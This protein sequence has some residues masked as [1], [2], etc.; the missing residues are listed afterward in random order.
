LTHAVCVL[1]RVVLVCSSV[2]VGSDNSN[3]YSL[4]HTHETIHND[5]P[6]RR[7]QDVRP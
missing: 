5:T 6:A 7:S 4:L 3:G 1:C 2:F